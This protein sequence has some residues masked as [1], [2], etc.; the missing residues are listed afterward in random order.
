MLLHRT[1]L[2]GFSTEG[3][4]AMIT[5][6]TL[7]DVSIRQ[8]VWPLLASVGALLFLFFQVPYASGYGHIPVPLWDVAYAL[9]FSFSE[10]SHGIFVFP[11]IIVLIFLKRRGLAEVPVRGSNS[12][13]PILASAA[14]F[15]WV[16]YLVDLQYIGFVAIQIFIAGLIVW[17]LG[18]RFFRSV[19]FI[20]LFLTFAWPFVFLDQYVSFPLRLLMSS[21]SEHFLNLIHVPAVREGTAI[22]S[23]PDSVTGIVTGQRFSIDVADP[24]SGMHSLFALTMM[25]SLYGIIVLRPWW[26]IA[27]T[28]IAAFPLAIFG[29]FCRILMLTWGTMRFGSR[30][31]VG[32][33]ENP[34]WFHTAAGL[35]VY[36][37]A[38]SGVFL[39]VHF[40]ARDLRP[41]K[42]KTPARERDESADQL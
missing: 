8:W 24:C 16:G 10:W 18:W 22:L 4:Y 25:A 35:V 17:F 27:I 5:P 30:F 37:A 13:L 40:L 7:R 41:K 12:G 11:L 9:W 15:Y 14:L 19:F 2:K 31:A 6:V 33:I 20:W 36:A 21:L 3:K 38:L 28:V 23:A 42:Q 1:K 34:T 26:Q 39:L 29:N 32:T